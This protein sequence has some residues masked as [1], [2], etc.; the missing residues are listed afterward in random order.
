MVSFH[1]VVKCHSTTEEAGWSDRPLDKEVSVKNLKKPF[2]PY[3]SPPP[4]L[5]P[6]GG[7]GTL[8]GMDR[9]W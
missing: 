8:T 6:G 1:S 5:N 9:V 7:I 2:N 3:P 4:A